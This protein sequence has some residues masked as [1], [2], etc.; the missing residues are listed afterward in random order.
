MVTWVLD[1]S[2]FKD[3]DMVMEAVIE[4]VP[5]KQKIFSEIDSICP[6]QFSWRE[7]KILRSSYWGP[8]IQSGSRNASTGNSQNK[9]KK[10]AQVILDLLTVGKVI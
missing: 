9:K 7:N 3:L 2:Q 6:P 4:S 10:S 1:Y 8:F 5:L